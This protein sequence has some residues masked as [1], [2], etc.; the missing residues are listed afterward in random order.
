LRATQRAFS[1]GDMCLALLYG[2][3]KKP[4]AYIVSDDKHAGMRRIL[5][6]DGTMSDMVNLARAKDAAKSI[7]ARKL[8]PSSAPRAFI[9]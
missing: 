8:S 9:G 3:S 6:V 2:N 5:S 4:I 1:V 7:A